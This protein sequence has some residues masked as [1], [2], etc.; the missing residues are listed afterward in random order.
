MPA[1]DIVKMT[2]PAGPSEFKECHY[3]SVSCCGMDP[4]GRWIRLSTSVCSA[5]RIETPVTGSDALSRI[6]SEI[7]AYKTPSQWRFVQELPKG[8]SGKIQ[9]MK[10]L[11]TL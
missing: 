4:T 1:S 11:E 5:L 10:L 6:R 2:M 8:P 3:N 7:G 9:R